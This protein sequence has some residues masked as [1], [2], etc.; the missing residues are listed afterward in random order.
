V[1]NVFNT[2]KIIIDTDPGHDDA[3]A[4]L[5]A[6]VSKELNVLGITCVAGNVPLELTTLNVLKIW[7]EYS[8]SQ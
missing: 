6:L 4:I 3:I 1:K 2:Q 7:F 8:L 5:L